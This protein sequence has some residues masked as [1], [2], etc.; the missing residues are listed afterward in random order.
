MFEILTGSTNI[1]LL[2]SRSHLPCFVI[3]LCHWIITENDS[4]RNKN[5]KMLLIYL[6]QISQRILAPNRN[7]LK[8]ISVMKFNWLAYV[9]NTSC[10]LDCALLLFRH[11]RPFNKKSSRWDVKKDKVEK[12][13]LYVPEMI[14]SVV[15]RRLTDK[16]GMSG[17][18][19]MSKTDPRIISIVL[20]PM[21]PPA[22]KDLVKAHKSRKQQQWR[23]C[24]QFIEKHYDGT[25]V[26]WQE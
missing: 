19:E 21:P 3:Y 20:A 15:K 17:G 22:T 23:D 8:H 7:I 4:I 10:N 11:H 2:S 13:Y 14:K 16:T 6:L 12:K 1:G 24:K 18:V 5:P 26:I 9:L 25:G